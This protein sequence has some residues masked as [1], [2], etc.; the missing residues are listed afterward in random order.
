M[1]DGDP[2]KVWKGY[3]LW[4]DQPFKSEGSEEKGKDV[5]GDTQSRPKGI[6]G[7]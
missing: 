4:M 2:E 7:F 3:V 6:N 5:A 1:E